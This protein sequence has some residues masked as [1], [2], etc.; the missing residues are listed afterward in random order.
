MV[1]SKIA[2]GS[3]ETGEAAKTTAQSMP[4]SAALSVSEPLP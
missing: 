4:M 2:F 3:G 1:T